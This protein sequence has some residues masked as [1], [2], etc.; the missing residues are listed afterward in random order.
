M[1]VSGG[2][3]L[4]EKYN[5]WRLTC[6]LK[7]QEVPKNLEEPLGEHVAEESHAG[8]YKPGLQFSPLDLKNPLECCKEAPDRQ[9]APRE[10]DHMFVE[11]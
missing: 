7:P 3:S 10:V 1:L 5:N 9:A 11:R 8:F 4:V 6:G 2:D